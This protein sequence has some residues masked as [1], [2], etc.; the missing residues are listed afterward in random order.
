M[1][2]ALKK[3]NV[4]EWKHMKKSIVVLLV[5]AQIENYGLKSRAPF[6]PKLC[7]YHASL[8]FSLSHF[9]GFVLSQHVC[10]H[11]FQSPPLKA[12]VPNFKL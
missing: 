12:C 9:S 1:N 4:Y 5:F 2:V 8:A 3:N 10:L 6:G 11:D 7:S